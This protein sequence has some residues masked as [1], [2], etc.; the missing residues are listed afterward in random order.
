MDHEEALA[1]LNAKLDDYRK[2][3]YDQL[4]A[5]VG[6]RESPEVVGASGAQYQ[7]EIQIIWDNKPG[8]DVRV[9]AAIDDGGWRAFL[10]LS[11]DFIMTLDGEVEGG[12]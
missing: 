6:M 8:G 12:Q 3:S 10:P 11:A 5:R 7:M 9:M 1:L 2:L 4:A